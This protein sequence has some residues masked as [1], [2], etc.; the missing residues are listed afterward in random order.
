MIDT[1]SVGR[2]DAYDIVDF[3]RKHYISAELA[4]GND[5]VREYDSS[6]DGTLEFNEFCQLVLPATNNSLRHVAEHRHHSPYFRASEPLPY[7]VVSLLVR[8]FEKELTL[9]RHRNESKHQLALSPDFIKV[10]AFDDISRGLSQIS[11]GDLTYFLERNGF[12]PRREDIEAILRRIDHNA[13][14]ALSYVDFCELT[15]IVDPHTTAASPEKHADSPLKE[16]RKDQSFNSPIRV[17]T[18]TQ[19]PGSKPVKTFDVSDD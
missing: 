5:I 19:Q 15:T 7:A 13:D 18:E 4:D 8:L 14:Q 3:L 2:I 10:R 12:Y 6:N 17:M 1:R 9:H 16:E 11:V